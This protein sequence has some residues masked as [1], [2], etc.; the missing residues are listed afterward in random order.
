MIQCQ[1]KSPAS[2]QW[3]SINL[4][5]KVTMN[6]TMNE[7]VNVWVEL[8]GYFAFFICGKAMQGNEPLISI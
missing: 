6:V 5:M 4:I 2:K 3:R 8:Y 7:D 1:V